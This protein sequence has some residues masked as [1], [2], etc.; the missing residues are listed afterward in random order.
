M[1]RVVYRELVLTGIFGRHLYTTWDILDGLLESGRV[2]L[3]HYVGEVMPLK[4]YKNALEHFSRL[5]G[6]AILLPEE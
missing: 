3:E 6:R 2:K 4:D 5:K 1:Y